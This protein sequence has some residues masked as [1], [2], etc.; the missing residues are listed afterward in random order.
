M[1]VFDH[2]ED[3]PLQDRVEELH[4]GIM[5]TG[6]TELRFD[7]IALVGRRYIRPEWDRKQWQHRQELRSDA[8]DPRRQCSTDSRRVVSELEIRSAAQDRAE[9]AVRRR[10]AVRRACSLERR[11]A[12]GLVPGGIQQA[13]LADA[14]GARQYDDL[15]EFT[16][17]SGDRLEFGGPSEQAG[18][19]ALSAHLVRRRVDLVGNDRLV[20]PLDQER[21]ER[22]G[23]EHGAGVVHHGCDRHDLAV[24]GLAEHAGSRVDRVAHQGVRPPVRGAEESGEDAARLRTLAQREPAVDDRDGER[25]VQQGVT[26]VAGVHGRSGAEDELE[27]VVGDV[28]VQRGHP[29]RRGHLDDVVDERTQCGSGSVA[30]DLVQRRTDAADHHEADGDES[31]LAPEVGE[32][33]ELLADPLWDE[34]IELVDPHGSLHGHRRRIDRT[35][36]DRDPTCMPAT[37]HLRGE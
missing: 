2:E 30:A 13:R 17:R 19:S 22:F 10:D 16:D 7:R 12:L 34:R 20:L 15:P 27:T 14:G 11:Q 21:F 29:E 18:G 31:V 3:R 8:L 36:E 9:H 24:A 35:A 28:G 33:L 6:P 23:L 5:D 25:C 37:D 32:R 1:Q 26:D 4:D